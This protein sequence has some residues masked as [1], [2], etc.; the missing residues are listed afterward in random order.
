MCTDSSPDRRA[1]A[2]V[3]DLELNLI[4]DA[5]VK[6]VVDIVADSFAAIVGGIDTEGSDEFA[7]LSDDR[8]SEKRLFSA[9]TWGRQR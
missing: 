5:A 7:E 9:P 4:D 1:A 8:Y 6:Q 3:A 2:F